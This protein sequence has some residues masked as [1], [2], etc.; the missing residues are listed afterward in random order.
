MEPTQIN[1][2]FIDAPISAM[3]H[4]LNPLLGVDNNIDRKHINILAYNVFLRPPFVKN[5]ESDH[6]DARLKE[7]I[8]LLGNYD[9]VCLEEMFGFLNRRKHKL[10]RCATKAGFLHYAES[11]SPSFFTTFLVDG[12]LLML[13]R[14]PIVE[15][16]FKPYPYGIFSDALSQKGILYGK[17]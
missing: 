15:Q 7:I 16:E 3:S 6:K 14:F 10:I 9:I 17:I 13:S 8:R 12:G 5:N 1:D 11:S 2:S 4:T